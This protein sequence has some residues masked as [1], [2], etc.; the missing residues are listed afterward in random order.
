MTTAEIRAEKTVLRDKYKLLRK[1]FAKE[2]LK[3]DAESKIFENV[4][5]SN[6][7]IPSLEI[8]DNNIHS[9]SK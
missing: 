7:A 1:D 4:I 8:H 9:S 2:Q 6:N 3:K 5:S